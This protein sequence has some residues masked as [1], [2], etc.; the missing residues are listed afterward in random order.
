MLNIFRNRL[1]IYVK[2]A[3]LKCQVITYPIYVD[4]YPNPTFITIS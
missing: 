1:A 3:S 2:G 4:L